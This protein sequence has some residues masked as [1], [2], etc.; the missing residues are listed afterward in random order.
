MLN[1]C[2]TDTFWYIADTCMVNFYLT[3]PQ[4]NAKLILPDFLIQI[5]IDQYLTVTYQYLINAY[6]IEP[7]F[8]WPWPILNQ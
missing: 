6:I 7:I 4:S 2:L 3:D 1:H 5:N 8:N